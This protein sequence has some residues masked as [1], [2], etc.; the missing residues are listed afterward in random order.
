MAYNEWDGAEWSSF[1]GA[2]RNPLAAHWRAPIWRRHRHRRSARPLG[3]ACKV[4][5][6]MPSKFVVNTGA[7]G[8]PLVHGLA[9]AVSAG[10][11]VEVVSGTW[12]DL[13]TGSASSGGIR[14]DGVLPR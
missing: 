10:W 4:R 12:L 3:I 13:G 2:R 8:A 5:Q 9:P 14:V 7:L 1:A 6:P 11:A